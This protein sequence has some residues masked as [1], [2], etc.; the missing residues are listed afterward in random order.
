MSYHFFAY[1]NR[2]KWIERWNLMRC[3]SRENIM[4][5]TASTAIVAHALGVINNEVFGGG[6]DANRMAVCALF[7]D[8]GEVI[9]G[10]L[11][12]PVK[13]FNGE[14]NKAYKG[15]EAVANQKLLS[16]LPDAFQETYA[17]LL[18]ADEDSYERQLVKAA[19]KLSAYIKCLEEM[20]SGNDE[21]KKAL[22][23]TEAGLKSMDLPEVRYFMEHF[24][25]SYS[26]T[27]DELE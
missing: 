22:L 9:T 11:P 4:E 23:S 10:D 24:I 6:A 25:E 8:V 2:M 20:K 21:F 15:L 14:I 17:E 12:T 13:Y 5:H 1:L 18:T 27:L 3:V 16:M 19:D 7:H 26:L